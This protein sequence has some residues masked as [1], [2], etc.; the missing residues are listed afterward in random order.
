MRRLLMCGL[1]VLAGCNS[2]AAPTTGLV[3]SIAGLDAK[4]GAGISQ[5]FGVYGERGTGGCKIDGWR[6]GAEVTVTSGLTST[7]GVTAQPNG[8]VTVPTFAGPVRVSVRDHGKTCVVQ[9]ATTLVLP[10]QGWVALHVSG[11]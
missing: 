2:P 7:S 5:A 10:T 6:C 3:S 9:E 4:A 11:C 8:R 1:F